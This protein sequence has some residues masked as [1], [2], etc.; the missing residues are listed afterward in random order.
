MGRLYPA[1]ITAIVYYIWNVLREKLEEGSVLWKH[2]CGRVLEVFVDE[3]SN[4]T[5]V[6][7]WVWLNVF[8]CHCV[9]IVRNVGTMRGLMRFLMN[10]GFASCGMTVGSLPGSLACGRALSPL[11]PSSAEK[12]LSKLSSLSKINVSFQWISPLKLDEPLIYLCDLI[13]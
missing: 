11:Y 4:T 2:C 1:W 3:F 6:A 10:S 7:C 8:F 9:H 5:I 12:V 13:K